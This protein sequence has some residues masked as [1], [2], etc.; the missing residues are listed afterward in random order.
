MNTSRW[1]EEISSLIETA[2]DLLQCVGNDVREA[3]LLQSSSSSSSTSS[4]GASSLSHGSADLGRI[5]EEELF[6][7]AGCAGD[8]VRIHYT[9]IQ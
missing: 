6:S 4:S 1:R 3:S 5:L 8:K 9:T 7:H 2:Q